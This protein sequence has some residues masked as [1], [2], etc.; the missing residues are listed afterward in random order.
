[1]PDSI[2]FMLYCFLGG[3]SFVFGPV[4]GAFVLF[5]SF[6]LLAGLRQYQTPI[7]AA[8]MILT[9][10]WLPNGLLSLRFPAIADVERWIPQTSALFR[11]AIRLPRLRS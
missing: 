3:L 4:I 10:L 1:V 11:R 2:F 8:I 5:L 7:Y 6:E 9:M